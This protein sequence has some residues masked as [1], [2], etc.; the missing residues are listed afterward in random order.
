MKTH[1]WNGAFLDILRSQGDPL[2]D[3]TFARI[4]ADGEEARIGALFA[5]LDTNDATPPAQSVPDGLGVLRV[6]WPTAA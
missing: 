5:R 3:E 4:L 6:Y 2:A 1:R